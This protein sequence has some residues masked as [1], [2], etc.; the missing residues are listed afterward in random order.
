MI[1]DLADPVT[2][3]VGTLALLIIALLLGLPAMRRVAAIRRLERAMGKL[4]WHVI[5][6]LG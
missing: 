1:I 3:A 4:F 2:I 5:T 6:V